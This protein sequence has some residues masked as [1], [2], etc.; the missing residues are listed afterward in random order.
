[1]Y[2]EWVSPRPK[3]ILPLFVS[4]SLSLS[5]SPCF[6]FL[7]SLSSYKYIQYIADQ[8]H[9]AS[10]KLPW[11]VSNVSVGQQKRGWG[12]GGGGHIHIRS[13]PRQKL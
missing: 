2:G 4:L 6:F 8:P 7:S 12:Q 13:F 10:K 3:I 1:M 11:G 9:V 5:I